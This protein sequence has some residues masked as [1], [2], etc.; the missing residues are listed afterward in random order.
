MDSLTMQYE[1]AIKQ[2][3]EE[4]M[5]ELSAHGIEVTDGKILWEQADLYKKPKFDYS[6][7]EDFIRYCNNFI[8]QEANNAAF[9]MNFEPIRVKLPDMPEI[10]GKCTMT[11]LK[12]VDS[13]RWT[14][15]RREYEPFLRKDT[16]KLIENMAN[17]FWHSTIRKIWYDGA[18]GV[19]LQQIGSS[20]SMYAHNNA[21]WEACRNSILAGDTGADKDLALSHTMGL[22]NHL[23]MFNLNGISEDEFARKGTFAS[24]PMNIPNMLLMTGKIPEIEILK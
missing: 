10:S 4:R 20:K 17:F 12:S 1:K 2:E 16:Q 11:E 5:K 18:K 8:I 3:F 13:A 15:F 9:T 23:L 24:K 14:I 22:S 7:D 21:R 6:F 19:I